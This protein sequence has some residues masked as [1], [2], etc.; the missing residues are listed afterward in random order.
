LRNFTDPPLARMSETMLSL[1]DYVV[2][3]RDSGKKEIN[4]E[5]FR[6]QGRRIW[7]WWILLLETV[8]PQDKSKLPPRMRSSIF[9]PRFDPNNLGCHAGAHNTL[10]HSADY[11]ENV[12]VKHFHAAFE[13]AGEAALYQLTIIYGAFHLYRCRVHAQPAWN[14]IR[15]IANVFGRMKAASA[16]DVTGV[17]EGDPV[18]RR[19]LPSKRLRVVVET[20][21][22]DE[23]IEVVPI[24]RQLFVVDDDDDGTDASP[25]PVPDNNSEDD[26]EAQSS[27]AEADSDSDGLVLNDE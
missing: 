15:G 12:G 2:Q 16:S 22:E 11:V 13:A 25:V 27:V 10:L 3:M 23:F 4:I 8:F 20:P 17:A 9:A 14:L 24:R 21:N 19:Y 5:A 18:P 1:I 6:E 26:T 7:N